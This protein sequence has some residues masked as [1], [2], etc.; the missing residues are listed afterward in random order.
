LTSSNFTPTEYRIMEVLQDGLPHTREEIHG[1]LQDELSSL[2]AIKP[3]I[4]S[5]RPKLEKQKLGILNTRLQ[6]RKCYQLIGLVFP[7]KS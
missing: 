5:L 7:D 6:G 1:C 4:C 3:H 2:D